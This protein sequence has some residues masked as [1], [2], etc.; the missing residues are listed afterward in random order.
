MLRGAGGRG[1]TPSSESLQRKRTTG[2]GRAL[3]A[4]G[5]LSK[6]GPN[7]QASSQLPLGDETP[8]WALLPSCPKVQATFFCPLCYPSVLSHTAEVIPVNCSRLLR[9]IH[10]DV[11]ARQFSLQHW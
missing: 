3:G 2:Y 10:L 11:P 7:A 9:L 4:S 5:L 1:T 8:G 6:M